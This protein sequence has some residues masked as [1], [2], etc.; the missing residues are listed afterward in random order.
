MMP[1]QEG[2]YYQPGVRPGSSFAVIF[3]RAD[4]TASAAAVSQSIDALWKVYQGLKSGTLRDLPGHPVP[5]GNLTVL[6]GFGI[7]A[8]ALPKAFKA[9]PEALSNY[10][11]FR[12]PLASGGGPLLIGSGLT[13]ADD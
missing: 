9:A 3:L 10:G 2:I 1:L 6:L 4:P 7:K 8:F 5:S 13:Y 12:S 11:L